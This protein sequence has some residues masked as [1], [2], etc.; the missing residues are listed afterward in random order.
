MLPPDFPFL[1]MTFFD[2]LE[3]RV[4]WLAFPGFLR[5]YALFHVLVF[6]LQFIR[7]NIGELFEFDRD[8]ILSGEVWRV[9][10]MF[11]AESQ[12][13]PPGLMSIIWLFFAVSIVFMISDG[14]EDAW[15]SFK[16]SLFYYTGM[17]LV[18]VMNFIYPV[19]IPASGVVLYGSAFIAFA[20]LYPRKEILLFFIIPVQI[21]FLG[22]FAAFLVILNAIAQPVLIPFYLIA[23]ANYFIWAGIPALRG[24]AR[25]IESSQRK[26]RFNGASLPADEAFHKCVVCHR[27]DIEDPEMDFRIGADGKEYCTQHLPD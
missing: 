23:Y 7:P 27:N 24:T 19:A 21:R 26:K 20:T 4:G 14:I 17:V 9:A 13:G 6:A 16:A 10:T 5:Y 25:Q 11:F 22:M 2:R 18:L 3:R 1:F 12:F 15:D 8:K